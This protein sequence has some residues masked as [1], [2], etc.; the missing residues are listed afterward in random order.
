[1]QQRKTPRPASTGAVV[2]DRRGRERNA[3]RARQ[4]HELYESGWTLEQVAQEFGVS[5]ERV[6]QILRQFSYGTRSVGESSA[7][8]RDQLRVLHGH[9][10]R[11]LLAEGL[12]T[13][14]AADRLGVTEH[15]VKTYLADDPELNRHRHAYRNRR[16]EKPRYS[17]EELIELLQ[18]ASHELGGVLTA[19][20]YTALSRTRQLPD[21]RPWPTHQT[22][23]LRFGTWVAALARAGLQSNKSS[24]IAGMRIFDR[25]HCIDALV[26]AQR[27]LGRFPTAAEYEAWATGKN[28]A[29]PSLATLRHRCGGWQSALRAAD[30]FLR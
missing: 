27:E 8:K 25:A 7:L 14:E 4:M 12:T 2:P 29:V 1:M 11:M 5:R 18:E 24:P 6:R 20:G 3:E 16:A 10:I 30:T 15:F 26:E 22:H 23:A 19:A 28:G 17:D 21:G 13:A 9:R